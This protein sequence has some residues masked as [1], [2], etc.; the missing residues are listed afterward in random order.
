MAAGKLIGGA[1]REPMSNVVGGVGI[2]LVRRVADRVV[3]PV[4]ERV[5]EGIGGGEKTTP[6]KPSTTGGD[7]AIV[8]RHRAVIGVVDEAEARVEPCLGS[9]AGTRGGGS[10]SGRRDGAVDVLDQVS[11]EGVHIVSVGGISRV[12]ARCHQ[13]TRVGSDV[14]QADDKAWGKLAIQGK[15]E[16]DRERASEM[17]VDAPDADLGADD[18]A[19]GIECLA[20]KRRYGNP[21]G[22]LFEVPYPK[23]GAAVNP[24]FLKVGRA[25]F[26]GLPLRPFSEFPRVK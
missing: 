10:S 13:A 21:K 26:G 24:S 7:Q 1:Q 14:P 8:V 23:I 18:A 25:K 4:V 5:A 2:E 16:V 19:L 9:A 22:L 6:C 11:G 17:R 20:A 15:I 12:A 3:L